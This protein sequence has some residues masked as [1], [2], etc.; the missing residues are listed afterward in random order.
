MTESLITYVSIFSCAAFAVALS[1][2][3]ST[4]ISERECPSGTETGPEID[5]FAGSSDTNIPPPRESTEFPESR[6]PPGT[7]AVLE[8]YGPVYPMKI[9]V[10]LPQ[11]VDWK[12]LVLSE[13]LDDYPMYSGCDARILF[14]EESETPEA[15]LRLNRYVACMIS[16]KGDEYLNF[17]SSPKIDEPMMTVLAKTLEQKTLTDVDRALVARFMVFYFLSTDI[18]K[19]SKGAEILQTMI[20]EGKVKGDLMDWAKEAIRGIEFKQS[21]RRHK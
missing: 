14:A 20:G 9:T 10:P 1:C 4:S 5:E 16:P 11:D 19:A 21:Q 15:V 8:I 18:E 12:D 2:T 13:R 7:K 6:V 3:D 17:R